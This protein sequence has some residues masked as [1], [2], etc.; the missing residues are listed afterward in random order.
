M[1][2]IVRITA[3]L[4]LMTAAFQA[5]KLWEEKCFLRENIVRLHV[6]ADSDSAED[7]ALKLQV[8]DAI[9]SYL[10]PYM[11]QFDTREEALGF[12]GENLEQIRLV[13]KE[14]LEQAGIDDAVTVRIGEESFDTR[15]YDTFSLPSGIYQ[16]VRVV[17][18]SGEGKNWWCV[19]FPSLCLPASSDAF[20][21][22]AVSAG[23][24]EELTQTLKND[25]EYELR[26]YFLDKLGCLENLFSGK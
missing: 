18:G 7:Q 19:A 9:V 2:K 15:H 25:G 24:N 23:L 17:I 3:V 8:K 4:I 5:G 14:V 20:E 1:F 13:G 22:M 10:T 16:S 26:F 12:L 6:V 21:E 11:E